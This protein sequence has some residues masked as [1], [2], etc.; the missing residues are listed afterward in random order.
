MDLR[1]VYVGLGVGIV[2]LA[3]LYWLAVTVH[4]ARTSRGK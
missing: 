1:W 3:L 4:T 2:A